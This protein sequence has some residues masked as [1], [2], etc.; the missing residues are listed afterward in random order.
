MS[1]LGYCIKNG[2][3]MMNDSK[4]KA[5][6][7]WDPPTKVPQ[8]KSFL[9]LVNYYRRFIKGYSVRAAPL[10]DLFKKNKT[11]EWD[12]RCQ[13]AFENLKKVVT[14]EPVLALRDHTK[15]FEI[16]TDASDFAI[17]GFLMQDRHSIAFENRKLNDMERHYIVK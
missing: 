7:E 11:C 9:G 15:V 10:T 4:V 5:I 2:K 3:L 6:Q 1:F 17:G 14:K 16:H 12:K 13:Q 8:L